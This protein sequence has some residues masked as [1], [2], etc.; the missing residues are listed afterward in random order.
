MTRPQIITLELEDCS[1]VLVEYV[2]RLEQA[3]AYE[4]D[5]AEQALQSQLT[6]QL[7]RARD[8][9]IWCLNAAKNGCEWEQQDIDSVEVE[10]SRL[11]KFVR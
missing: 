9:L 4:S 1:E 11:R 10:V 7:D 3:L 5:C 8:T 6:K 2:D